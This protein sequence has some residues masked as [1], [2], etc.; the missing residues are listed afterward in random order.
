LPAPLPRTGSTAAVDLHAEMHPAR[1]IGGDFYDYFMLDDERLALTIADV[2]G[3]AFR[4][5]SSWRSRARSCAA[6]TV[7]P[8]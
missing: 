3:R 6:W 4:P 7:S 2:V 5:R 1:E 8:I